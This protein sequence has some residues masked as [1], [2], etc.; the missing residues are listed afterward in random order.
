VESTEAI[1]QRK[2]ERL[3][4]RLTIPTSQ[5]LYI[6]RLRRTKSFV[7]TQQRT[8][9]LTYNALPLLSS[10]NEFLYLKHQLEMTTDGN[11]GPGDGSSK[12]F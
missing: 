6:Q 3:I 4:L 12:H 8:L 10:N 7:Y 9:L 11:Y 5:L 1:K 2:C